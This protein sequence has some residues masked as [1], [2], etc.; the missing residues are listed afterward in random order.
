MPF[1]LSHAAAVLPALRTGGTGRAGLVPAV[2]VAGSFAPDMTYYAASVLSG[3]M[4]FGDVTHSVPGV[5]TVDVAIAW[6]L[7]GV[8]LLLREPL[9]ALLPA[10][11]QARPAALLRCGAPRARVTPGLVARW[12]VSAVLGGLTH[13]VWDAFT[14]LDRWGM[15]VFPVL[16]EEIAG[17]PLY[18]YLQYG[19][20][21]VAAVVIAV[22]VTVAL[23]R[24]RVAE[25][26]GPVA[27]VPVAG[28]P[29]LSVRD[30]WSALV[31]V[32]GCAA[33][34]AFQR[35][36]RWWEYWGATAKYWELIPTLC[37][38]AGAGLV[39]GLVL[40]GAAVRLWRPVPVPGSTGTGGAERERSR[41]GVR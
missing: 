25:P 6:A 38:G 20:S 23:R 8:W 37:F 5:L 21:A 35:A 16:G 10:R 4:E 39:A 40:Y 1:T 19:G 27:G 26:G 31:V 9:V 13:V 30:R 12:Y 17:S 18:W 11:L 24:A 14:H 7:V 29:V 28:V 15:R 41:P 2:L 3:A 33:V 34:A 36:S 32:G 22:F